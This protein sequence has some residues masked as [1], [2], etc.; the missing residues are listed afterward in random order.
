MMKT[1]KMKHS[2]LRPS[3][4]LMVLIWLISRPIVIAYVLLC[5]VSK[6]LVLPLLVFRARRRLNKAHRK[7]HPLPQFPESSPLLGHLSPTE[8]ELL[9]FQ[10]KGP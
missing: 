10:Q 4:I 6:I 9:K 1:E 5:G 3:S 2:I 8:V 7:M